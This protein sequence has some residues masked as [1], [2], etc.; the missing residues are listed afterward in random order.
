MQTGH[1]IYKDLK[2]RNVLTLQPKGWLDDIVINSYF[3]YLNSL[4]NNSTFFIH[5]FLFGMVN[6]ESILKFNDTKKEHNQN[7]HNKNAEVDEQ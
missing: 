5:P 2:F 6:F 3:D 1:I 7:T 4:E